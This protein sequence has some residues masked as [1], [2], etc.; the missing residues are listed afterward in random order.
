MTAVGSRRR[1]QVVPRWRPW[2]TT[3]SLGELAHPGPSRSA[4]S[5]AVHWTQ[6]QQEFLSRPSRG[7]A[8]DLLA[9]AVVLDIDPEHV[10]H[11]AKQLASGRPGL[12][13]ELAAHVDDGRQ[14]RLDRAE[15]L[16]A[17]S[18]PSQRIATLRG[19]VR[20]EPRNTVRWVDLGLA[21][22]AI[23]RHDKAAGAL[24]VARNLAPHDRFVL[25]SSA[26]LLA[27]HDGLDEAAAV[28][29]AGSTDDPW[30]LAALIAVTDLA[31]RKV[32]GVRAATQL[33]DRHQG[34]PTKALAELAAAVA[35]VEY[36]A[37]SDRRARRRLRSALLDPTD[38]AFAQ[39]V[40][41]ADRTTVDLDGVDEK[42]IPRR[43]EAEARQA[44]QELRWSDAAAAAQLWQLDQ[45]FSTSP[46]TF[47]SWVACE[48]DDWQLARRLAGAGFRVHPS[49]PMI[50]NNLAL[51]LAETGELDDAARH[52]KTARTVEASPRDRTVLAATEGLLLFRAGWIEQGRLRYD[53]AIRAFQRQQAR[54]LAARAAVMLAREEL[55]L[56]TE[57]APHALERAI[58]LAHGVRDQATE[59]RLHRIQHNTERVLVASAPVPHVELPQEFV[60]SVHQVSA[61]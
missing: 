52:L 24:R 4:A 54:D 10:P 26:A 37:G 27:E 23:G 7:R 20:R 31:D 56:H 35:S 16:D 39:A 34:P 48:A 33:L 19:V 5:S 6:Q 46:A 49:D 61:T 57:Q 18:D 17:P 45:P 40:W 44:A 3:A 13:L 58:R 14:Q 60:H 32:R 53:T 2:R 42:A 11:E 8:A 30:I 59:S 28:L 50:L 21:Y 38:N 51:A 36:G 1:R 55:L 29:T 22:A 15:N 47:G 9:S 25:R 41:L 43:Y 12:L